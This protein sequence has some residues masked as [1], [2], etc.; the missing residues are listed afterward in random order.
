M[1][2]SYEY[3]R[4]NKK[5]FSDYAKKYYVTRSEQIKRANDEW[6]QRNPYRA[7]STRSISTH[8][9]RG[10][11]V[12][13]TRQQLEELAKNSH[14]CVICLR[15]LNWQLG[16]KGTVQLDSPALDRIN[17]EM[18]IRP[19]NC[20]ITC[21]SCGSTKRNRTMRD[22]VSYCDMVSKRFMELL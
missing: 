12:I 14:N 2:Y 10:F 8:K 20:Q 9:T 13:I 19:D 18:E 22:F 16:N 4:R 15:P 7:W 1:K 6:T 5:K 11:T 21:H 3:Y 17:N